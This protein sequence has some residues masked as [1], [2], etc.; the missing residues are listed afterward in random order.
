[1][2]LY[3]VSLVLVL[4][5]ACS[6]PA[7]ADTG[8]LCSTFG[9]TCANPQQIT[10]QFTGDI[11]GNLYYVSANFHDWVRVI[12][13]N[14]D[15]SWTSNWFFNNQLGVQQPSVVFGHAN[16]GDVLV[17]QLCDQEEQRNLCAPS[18]KNQYL[19]ASDPAYSGDGMNH[20]LVNVNGGAT[21]TARGDGPK[22][23]LIWLEDLDTAH[24]SDWDY[25]DEVIGL[26][27]VLVSFGAEGAQA[28]VPE[29]ATISLLVSGL[30]AGF[31]G[32]LKKR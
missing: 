3:W 14:P 31:L 8:L 15:N 12:D 21:T 26:H 28:P 29:P 27:N 6:I 13:T 25:N 9:A 17:V 30:G 10:A 7:V 32:W 20:A 24:D 19:L 23:W 22:T 16:Q 5:A 11:T 4:M 18:S 1:M 2:R